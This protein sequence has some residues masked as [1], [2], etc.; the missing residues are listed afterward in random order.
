[1]QGSDDKVYGGALCSV[2]AKVD[3]WTGA[4]RIR[5]PK[6]DDLLFALCATFGDEFPPGGCVVD[7]LK[8]SESFPSRLVS[9]FFFNKDPQPCTS[10]YRDFLTKKKKNTLYALHTNGEFLGII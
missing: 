6:H 1:M 8:R 3:K 5:L 9:L 10:Y 2:N 4:Y 7:E